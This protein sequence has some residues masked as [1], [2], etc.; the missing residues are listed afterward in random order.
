M[1]SSCVTRGGV[2]ERP[3]IVIVATPPMLLAVT[4]E[5]TK[6]IVVVAATTLLPSSCVV[7]GVAPGT[8]TLMLLPDVIAALTPVPKKLIPVTADVSSVPLLLTATGIPPVPPDG[9]VTVTTPLSGVLPVLTNAALSRSSFRLLVITAPAASR[10]LTLLP[11]IVTVTS[12]LPT[13]VAVTP[14][15]TKL[16][17][18]VAVAMFAPSSC[19]IRLALLMVTVTLLALASV[20]VTPVPTKLMTLAVAATVLPSSLMASA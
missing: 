14:D 9:A 4:P 17:L 2:A 13:P 10:T 18:V 19:V 1:P 7:K 3:G 15:P 16:N 11:G 20:L 6:F 8:V 12:L 5:P